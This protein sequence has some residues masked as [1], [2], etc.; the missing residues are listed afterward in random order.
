MHVTFV[1]HQ[2]GLGIRRF[3]NLTQGR[4]NSSF[5]K[6][7]QNPPAVPIQEKTYLPSMDTHVLPGENPHIFSYSTS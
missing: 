2:K 6:K 3:L 5:G 1:S 4:A 7:D